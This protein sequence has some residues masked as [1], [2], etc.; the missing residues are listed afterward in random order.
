LCPRSNLLAVFY[1]SWNSVSHAVWRGSSCV[2][3]RP[4]KNC[5]STFRCGRSEQSN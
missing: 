4:T 2:N 3:A 1:R 5:A